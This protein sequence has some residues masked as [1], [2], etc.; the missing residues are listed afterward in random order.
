MRRWEQDARHPKPSCLSLR[1]PPRRPWQAQIAGQAAK[2]SESTVRN[3]YAARKLGE[4]G[5]NTTHELW[6]SSWRQFLRAA[7]RRPACSGWSDPSDTLAVGLGGA[8]PG[9]GRDR[10]TIRLSFSSVTVR[11]IDRAQTPAL[12]RFADVE[13]NGAFGRFV[14]NERDISWLADRG[15]LQRQGRPLEFGGRRETWR[16]TPAAPVAVGGVG[17]RRDAEKSGRSRVTESD[18]I[19][20][21]HRGLPSG[22][23]CRS[24]GF[25]TGVSCGSAIGPVSSE[26]PAAAASW[27]RATQAE[28]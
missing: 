17:G 10:T 25:S 28:K 15:P 3:A 6:K 24:P 8:A 9:A 11:L 14:E 20:I 19:G 1:C 7:C 27:A 26:P 13:P 23:G 21:R 5:S 18:S 12:R 4:C 16:S 2:S 22:G